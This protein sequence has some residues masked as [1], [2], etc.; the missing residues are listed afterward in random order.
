VRHG[1]TRIHPLS[2]FSHVS[3]GL[4]VITEPSSHMRDDDVFLQE[5]FGTSGE[6]L[7]ID[8]GSLV[9]K[10]LH[11]L[12]IRPRIDSGI[13]LRAALAAQFQHT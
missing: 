5:H 12:N 7:R 8:P 10:L 6:H 3:M 4:S 11:V 1:L 9:P 13:A 2:T